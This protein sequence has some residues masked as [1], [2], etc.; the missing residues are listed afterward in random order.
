MPKVLVVTGDELLARELSGMGLVTWYLNGLGFDED[1]PETEAEEDKLI[2][3]DA[4][5]N[6]RLLDLLLPESDVGFRGMEPTTLRE[7]MQDW[8]T[9]HG[10]SL[11][12]ER[13][14]AVASLVGALVENQKVTPDERRREEA[15]WARV[16]AEHDWEDED[17]ALPTREEWVGVKGIL[18]ADSDAVW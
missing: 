8:G 14:V 16:L 4:F 12:L 2:R 18:L 17:A 6:L 9:L 13:S 15:E 5:L 7:K 1:A 10:E 11:M 3:E